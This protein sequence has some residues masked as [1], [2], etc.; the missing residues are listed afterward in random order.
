MGIQSHK[1]STEDVAKTYFLR[2]PHEL[3]FGS[4]FASLSAESI[5]IYS[6]LSAL[7]D[8]SMRHGSTFL[9]E[10]GYYFINVRTNTLCKKFRCSERTLYRRLTELES[11]GL[12]ERKRIGQ[13]KNSIIYVL[14]FETEETRFIGQTTEEGLETT[15]EEECEEELTQSN[16]S[17]SE[18][19][20]DK[21]VISRPDKIVS[22]ELVTMEHN[23]TK[24]CQTEIQKISNQNN[25][26]ESKN[27]HNTS[28]IKDGIIQDNSVHSR[29]DK[30]VISRQ[31]KSVISRPDKSGGQYK[32]NYYIENHKDKSIIEK[33]IESKEIH[34]D[35][36]I[37]SIHPEKQVEN[38]QIASNQK[39]NFYV[40]K[41]RY[42]FAEVLIDA[43][44][45]LIDKVLHAK[46]NFYFINQER[47]SGE[48]VRSC[49][50][51][52]QTQDICY[53]IER[54]RHAKKIMKPEQYMMSVLYNAKMQ[55]AL[56]DGCDE[57]QEIALHSIAFAN[58]E[59]PDRGREY[60][61]CRIL[62]KSSELIRCDTLQEEKQE[63][64]QV[65]EQVRKATGHKQFTLRMP[66]TKGYATKVIAIDKDQVLL[67]TPGDDPEY[68][69]FF[70]LLE[71]IDV[72]VWKDQTVIR[73][74]ERLSK[75]ELYELFYDRTESAFA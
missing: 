67:F 68:L 54:M 66:G 17:H 31:D 3:L 71:R 7:N 62:V 57:N 14:S 40:V 5:L 20:S 42:P 47:I 61:F 73:T 13:G 38:N 75:E 59:M 74:T 37:L 2:V 48:Q 22:E 63:T 55:R 70:N 9:D 45:S 32:D 6:Y 44:K 26:A 41:Q 34:E 30:S 65:M 64:L 39:I 29:Q 1:I 51:K 56:T 33:K 36:S 10:E 69:V 58:N 11:C 60:L 25:G 8:A 16:L 52:L 24:E 28:G 12:I 72:Y 27:I 15:F 35:L 49:F 46:N 19:G 18:S 50:G 43:I 21:S 4:Y 53:V 23:A